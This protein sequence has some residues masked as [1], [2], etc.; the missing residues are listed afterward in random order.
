MNPARLC[1]RAKQ[2][3]LI[4]KNRIVLLLT[5]FVGVVALIY[6]YTRMSGERAADEEGDQ[7]ITAA[8]RVEQGTNGESFIK[9][10][11]NEQKL[12]GLEIT[13]LTERTHAPQMKAYGQVLDPAPL[14]SRLSD[15]ASARAALDATRN[16]YRRRKSLFDNG[17]NTSVKSLE[18]AAAAMKRDEITL[19]SNEAQL[20]ASWGKSVADEPDLPAFVQSLVQL[21]TV[22]VRLDL[23]A[24]ESLA[25][26]PTGARVV[27][28]GED[29]PVPARFLG[30]ATTTDPQSQGR[31]FLF[32]VTN[33]VT[34][35]TPGLVVTGF[36]QLP[37]EPLRGAL[38]PDGAVVRSAERAWIYVQTGT[39]TFV[40]REIALDH[41]V[42][43]GWFVT[44][45][46]TAGE[47]VV[48][49]GAQT[50]LSE[51]RK[52]QIKLED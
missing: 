48:V 6:G 45:G 41:P 2:P 5:I 9:L 50:L 21:E 27:V 17:Q 4:M 31:G 10:E 30:V 22:L 18:S 33:T 29:Q 12:V 44:H 13:P 11:P 38:V 15:I 32:V 3:G 51:E 42:N 16:E 19:Q 46:V 8:A 25:G 40:R 14:V 7:T 28:P 36:L 34:R 23:P 35:L 52:G 1:W 37:G 39:T 49:T 20:L 26:M 43:G 24:G 47:R